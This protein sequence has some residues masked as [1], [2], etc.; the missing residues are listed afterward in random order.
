MVTAPRPDRATVR[1]PIEVRTRALS[2]LT[3]LALPG[4]EGAPPHRSADPAP[5]VHGHNDYLQPVPLRTALALG[6]GSVEADVFLAGGELRVGHDRSQLRPGRT[7]RSLYLDPLRAWAAEHAGPAREGE[8][9]FV[10]LVDIKAD[11]DAAWP[12]LRRELADHETMLTR[13]AGGHIERRAVTVILSGDRPWR[14]VA[15]EQQRLCALDG[16]LED[17]EAT[18]APSPALVPWVS[19]AWSRVSSWTGAG[20]LPAEQ[21]ERIARLV[22]RAH[23]LGLELRFWGAPDRPEAWRALQ[24]LGVDRIGTDRPREAVSALAASR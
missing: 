23:A 1:A 17:L 15:E 4:C 24:A 8:R 14:L 20:A 3:L 6:L 7:L 13:F 22:A 21:R 5:C 11:G 18:P 12:V 10:L 16:R 19:A 9:P 2:L